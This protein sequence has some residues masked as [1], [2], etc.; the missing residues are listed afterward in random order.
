MGFRAI[1]LCK[2]PEQ[3]GPFLVT[4]R[5][6]WGRGR[7]GPRKLVGGA[8]LPRLVEPDPDDVSVAVFGVQGGG[9]G[10]PRQLTSDSASLMHPQVSPDGRQIAGTRILLLKEIWRLP[11]DR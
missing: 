7:A 3:L 1:C 8:G 4:Q 5:P 9:R 6:R 2:G 10:E 11:I